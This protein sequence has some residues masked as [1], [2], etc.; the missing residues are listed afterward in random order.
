MP[1]INDEPGRLNLATAPQRVRLAVLEVRTEPLLAK[2]L[3][4]LGLRPGA[5]IEVLHGVSGGGRV[6]SVAGSRLVLDRT[7]LRAIRV[8]GSDRAI[9]AGEVSR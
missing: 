5:P 3:G 9:P 8:D 7:I 1:E 4:A 2:R 6:I